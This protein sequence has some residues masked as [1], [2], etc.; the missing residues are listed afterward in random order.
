MTA[1]ASKH[2]K[3]FE[4]AILSEL[5]KEVKGRIKFTVVK[6]SQLE[7]AL[8]SFRSL[9]NREIKEYR[10]AANAG[11]LMLL[12]REPLILH[13]KSKEALLELFLQSDQKGGD[14]SG[15]N[16]QHGYALGLLEEAGVDGI[17][18]TAAAFFFASSVTDRSCSCSA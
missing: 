12:R 9:E 15:K 6:N 3:A 18:L 5:R 16:L 7:K 17:V 10:A 2:G 14:G 1:K 11:V 8:A 4:Y 13:P